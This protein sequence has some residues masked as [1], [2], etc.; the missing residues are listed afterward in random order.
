METNIFPL[1]LKSDVLKLSR[2]RYDQDLLSRLRNDHNQDYSFFRNGDFT[3]VSP[4]T[5]KSLGEGEQQLE[6][7]S[8]GNVEILGSLIRHVFFRSFIRLFGYTPLSFYPLRFIS[9][10]HDAIKDLLPDDLK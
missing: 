7:P 9:K 1:K 5:Q 2:L 4:D 8:E 10:K 6:L 3:Y